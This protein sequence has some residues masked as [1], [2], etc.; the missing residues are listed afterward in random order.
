MIFEGKLFS[1]EKTPKIYMH[2]RCCGRN[3]DDMLLDRKST[4]DGSLVC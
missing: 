2:A 4:A 1:H 3:E